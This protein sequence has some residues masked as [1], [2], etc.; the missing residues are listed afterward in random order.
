MRISRSPPV[1]PPAALGAVVVD[2]AAAFNRPPN[3]AEPAMTAGPSDARLRNDRRSELC[4][5]ST[6]AV[7]CRVT[8]DMTSLLREFVLDSGRPGLPHR[9][10]YC[11]G[12]CSVL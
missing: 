1:S 12:I 10:F 2:A 8:S 5:S 9:R 7:A 6:A 4:G 11:P 3:T